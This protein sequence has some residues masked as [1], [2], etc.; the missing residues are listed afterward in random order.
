MTSS[1]C[2]PRGPA[3]GPRLQSCSMVTIATRSF[4]TGGPGRGAQDVVLHP[5]EHLVGFSMFSMNEFRF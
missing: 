1:G 5:A 2:V 4:R 3:A